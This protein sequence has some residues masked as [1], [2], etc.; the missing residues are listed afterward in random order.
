MQDNGALLAT[1]ADRTGGRV[2]ELDTLPE[3]INLY[4]RVD[5]EIPLAPKRVWDLLAIIAAALFLLD[6]ATRRLAFDTRAARDAASRAIART[7]ETSEASVA[8]WKRARSRSRGSK[9]KRDATGE[10]SAS[11]SG[12]TV[13]EAGDIPGDFDVSS[14]LSGDSR[15]TTDETPKRS[16]AETSGSEESSLDRLKRAKRRVTGDED[17]NE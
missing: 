14:E 3:T 10:T 5:L 7:E 17:E 8:A 9:R 13:D 6:V 11:V 4:D 2:I 15:S 12:S 16:V 1:V